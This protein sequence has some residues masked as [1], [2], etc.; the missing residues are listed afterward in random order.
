[1]AFAFVAILLVCAAVIA[2]AI[3]DD[4]FDGFA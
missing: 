2:R 4:D 3:E 1:M